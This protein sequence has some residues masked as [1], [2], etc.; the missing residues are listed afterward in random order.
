MRN[1][2]RGCIKIFKRNKI[3]QYYHDKAKNLKMISA[4]HLKRIKGFCQ[5][6]LQVL[7][8]INLSNYY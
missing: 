7:V 5:G 6:I 2:I 1:S 4:A 3:D 8:G